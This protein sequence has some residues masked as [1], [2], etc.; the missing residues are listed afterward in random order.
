M[1]LIAH[2]GLTNHDIKE[3]TMEAFENALSKGYD[4][5]ELDVRVTKDKKVVVIHN[6]LINITS[7]GHGI[8][9]NLTYKELLKYNFGSKK[10]PSKIPLLEQVIK[11]INN[12]IIIIELKEKIDYNLIDKILSKNDTNNY[13][14]S[15]FNKN[16]LK[17]IDRAKYKVG[18]IDAI[19]N[20]TVDFTKYDFILIL[21]DLFNEQVYDNLKKF[22]IEPIIYGTMKKINLSNKELIAKLKYII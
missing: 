13:Y 10:I 22:K 1:Y 6:N 7:N 8:V 21:E 14:I 11:K 5:I 12:K 4:G 3:N 9:N 18:L 2:R 16:F 20:R 19:F 17:D 15:S